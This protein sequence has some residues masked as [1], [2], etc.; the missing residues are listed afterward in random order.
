MSYSIFSEVVFN[1]S[2]SE[3]MD[4]QL[5]VSVDEFV[6]KKATNKLEQQTKVINFLLKEWIFF[7]CFFFFFFFFL[8]FSAT[9]RCTL[10]YLIRI[11]LTK[12]YTLFSLSIGTSYN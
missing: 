9:K 3:N 10:W 12:I 7:S 1:S 2:I 5:N 11:F 8:H 4:L 6:S